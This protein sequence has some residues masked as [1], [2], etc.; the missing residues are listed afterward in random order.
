MASVTMIFRKD[1]V[2]KQNLAPIH[3]RIIKN[4]KISYI[5]S[6]IMIPIDQ[7]DNDKNKVKSAHKSSARLNSFLANKFAELQDNVLEFETSSNHL[8]SKMLKEK[9]FGKKETDFFQ[10]ANE[11]LNSYIQE[12]K[13]GTYDKC[14]SIIKKMT[15]YM[16]EK[17]LPL[18]EINV[19]F[20]IKYETYLRQTMK[21]KTNT[22]H[23]DLK[24]IRRVFN[25][26]Y[27][28]ELIEHSQNPFLRYQL[29]QDKTNRVF[30]NE[31]E[32]KLIEDVLLPINTRLDLHRDMFVF[33][34]YAGG[35]RVSDMLLLKWSMF[36]GKNINITIH[37][38]KEQLSI[39]VPN[40]GLE[41]INKYAELRNDTNPYIF[42]M[43]PDSLDE[44]NA[45]ELDSAISSATAYINKNLK[46]IT[47][48][49]N[50]IKPCSF[51]IARH[52]WACRALQKGISID[53]VQKLMGHSAISQTQ[54][55]AKIVSTELDNAMD[56]FN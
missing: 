16:K 45:R 1:K 41:I 36:D 26:A 56:A 52:T 5:S 51:H 32:L 31:T 37:K 8:T 10:L 27:R 47:K 25:E 30:L 17:A 53:K 39:K 2:N 13:I 42:P 15:T 29:K 35:L 6:G 19:E 28:R 48:K 55:Y 18:Q 9:T 22:I 46:I 3:F 33:A 34:S 12:N 43:L 49:C 40:T 7:W 21:N 50:I 24:F 23:K 38:T 4:R 54:I 44:K 20:L 11:I 14:T